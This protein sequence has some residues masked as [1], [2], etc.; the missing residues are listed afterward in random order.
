M[1]PTT[2]PPQDE[3]LAT[4]Q[5]QYRMAARRRTEAFRL[6]QANRQVRNDK[7]CGSCQKCLPISA[8]YV[9]RDTNGTMS[10]CK[11]CN[12]EK[13]VA[14]Q[15]KRMAE[16]PAAKSAS[17]SRIAAWCAR[18]PLLAAQSIIA[19][20][21]RYQRRQRETLAPAYVRHSLRMWLRQDEF[22]Q[23]MIDA[24]RERLKL[25]RQLRKTK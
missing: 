18:N 25:H 14:R 10:I 3:R 7:V 11:K 16:S 12:T 13:C 1:T 6:K 23:G 17:L 24:Q 8:F 20:V 15:R 2:R 21:C 9:R 22:P 19:G 4:E 5:W